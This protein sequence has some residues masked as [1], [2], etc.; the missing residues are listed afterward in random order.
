MKTQSKT[1]PA[2][3]LAIVVA[4]AAGHTPHRGWQDCR[5]HRGLRRDL[6]PEWP[7]RQGG[8]RRGEV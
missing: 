3:I 5:G 4:A 2:S 1:I 8:R 7:S 6:G